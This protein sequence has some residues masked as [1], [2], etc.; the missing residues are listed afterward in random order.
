MS[1]FPLQFGTLVCCMHLLACGAQPNICETIRAFHAKDFVYSFEQ[2]RVG[3]DTTVTRASTDFARIDSLLISVDDDQISIDTKNWSLEVFKVQQWAGFKRASTDQGYFF[4]PRD[5]LSVLYFAL[6]NATDTAISSTGHHTKVTVN[7]VSNQVGL[8]EVVTTADITGRLRTIIA[9]YDAQ[10]GVPF[11]DEFIFNANSTNIERI[12]S[13]ARSVKLVDGKV[14]L[15]N[16]LENY[17]ILDMDN[18]FQNRR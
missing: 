14:V 8:S 12:E 3:E 15:T 17:P 11:H 13:Y 5:P 7:V 10:F 4:S 9:R 6:E 2:R 1:K 16:A 18:P